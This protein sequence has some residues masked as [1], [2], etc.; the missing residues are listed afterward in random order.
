ELKPDDWNA[1]S[2]L[3]DWLQAFRDATTGMS[4]T[5]FPMLLTVHAT[6]RGLQ[7]HIKRV[8]RSLP[9]SVSPRMKQS[10]TNAHMK[11]AEY[12]EKFDQSLFYT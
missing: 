2:L 4:A 11:L 10:L 1:L 9:D 3:E 7:D 5:R 6:F 12:Y 8:L